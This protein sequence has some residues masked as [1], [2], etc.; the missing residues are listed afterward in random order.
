MSKII[1]KWLFE[2][3]WGWK[4]EGNTPT[5][6]KYLIVVAPH[7]SNWDFIIG[8]L[9]RKFTDG[10]NPRYLA[11]K[12]LFVW[13]LGYFFRALGGYPVERS[14]NT[15]F[16]EGLMK[17]YNREERFATTITPEGTRR[18]NVK[19]KTGFY[20]VAKNANVPIIKVAFDYGTK[21]VF[22]DE[23]YHI[24]QGVDETII[25]FKKYFSQ[26]KG[27]NPKDGVK[28]PE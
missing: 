12:E 14:K 19:W 7:T 15:N 2:S 21:T 10:F 23:P 25:E 6:P 4:V 3:V 22:I 26:Y 11:K 24:T 18:Y 20:Y 8:V 16:V 5:I 13:P 17:V 1:A 9:I 27:R 28:W